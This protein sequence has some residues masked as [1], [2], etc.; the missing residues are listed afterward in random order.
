MLLKRQRLAK[1]P[2]LTHCPGMSLRSELYYE[3]EDLLCGNSFVVYG[4]ACLIYDCDDFTK[5]WYTR[6]LSISQSP[7]ALKKPAPKLIYQSVPKHTGYGTEED[8]MNGVL[9]LNPKA[10]KIDMKKVFK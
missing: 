4:R 9:S 3:P 6:N 1:T 7:V 10:P 2:I 5:E 8:S